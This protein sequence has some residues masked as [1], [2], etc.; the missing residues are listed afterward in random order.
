[1][2]FAINPLHY[3]APPA[4]VAAAAVPVR[5]LANN[6]GIRNNIVAAN[7]KIGYLWRKIT[8]AQAVVNQPVFGPQPLERRETTTVTSS[9][10]V[11]RYGVLVDEMNKSAGADL[12]VQYESLPISDK[13]IYGIELMDR[14]NQ[15]GQM[16]KKTRLGPAA[17]AK[18]RVVFDGYATNETEA[19]TNNVDFEVQTDVDNMEYEKITFPDRKKINAVMRRKKNY[20]AYSKL[21]YFLRCKYHLKH[22]DPK[23]INN[24]VHDARNWMLKEDR[25][26]DNYVDYHI[27]SSA[28]LCAFLV[29]EEELE[30][31]AVV[32][33]NDA[34]NNMLHLNATV[35]GDLGRC[36][37]KISESFIGKTL[38]HRRLTPAA[39][40]I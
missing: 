27:M 33:R 6:G 15:Q 22:R 35:T 38:P 16:E 10:N 23:T 17:I 2:A 39:P 34:Y 31:R 36:G 18:R 5:A 32:K 13:G 11:G 4:R 7:N 19:Q 14:R 28:V 30:F 24:L 8:K 9:I 1:M 21:L 3:V 25:K 20:A 26:C 12:L 37:R 40:S 29:S